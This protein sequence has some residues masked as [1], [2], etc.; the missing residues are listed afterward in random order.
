MT[1]TIL[2]TTLLMVVPADAISGGVP[3]VDG[4]YGFVAKIAMD[5]RACTGALLSQEWVI[6]AASCFPENPQGDAPARATTVTVGRTNLTGTSGHVAR[7]TNLVVRTD[8]DLALA[9][10]DAL[11][12]DVTPIALGATLPA[13]GAS[14][15]VAGYGRTATEWVPDQLRTA[16]FSVASTA[17]TTLAVTGD[18]GVDTCKGDAGGP[19]FTETG[20]QPQLLA[21]SSISW[22][23][24]CTT[25]TETRQ[26]SSETRVDDLADW[27]RQITYATDIALTGT[28]VARLQNGSAYLKD[29][30][31]AWSLQWDGHNNAVTKIR[32]DGTRV[33]VLLANGD[34][35]VKDDALPTLGWLHESTDITDFDLSGQRLAAVNNG[36]VYIKDGNLQGS[37]T[38]PWDTRRGTVTTVHVDSTRIGVLLTN[39]EVWVKD[40]TLPDLGWLAEIDATTD[41]ALSG[42]RFAAVKNGNVYVKDGDLQG[43]WTTPWDTQRGTVTTV[44]LD[45]TRIGV[46]RTNKEVWVKDDALP[47]LGWLAESDR[48]T[49]FDLAGN[50]IGI[51]QTGQCRVQSGN[52]QGPWTDLGQ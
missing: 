18:N 2:A 28:R 23:H 37:W 38:T 27:V 43:G 24:G 22:Q 19:A 5:G 34:L 17:A 40:D 8:R 45:G 42:Q 7:V 39:S 46:L 6:T 25:V 35:W 20:G 44:R 41:F 30:D 9:Q 51:V 32:V 36:T 14:L 47:S 4:N 31:G 12:S 15:R 52:L 50:R 11:V 33:G 29:G 1:A 21:I 16:T 26:G 13:V 48:T 3:A 10:L 49:A